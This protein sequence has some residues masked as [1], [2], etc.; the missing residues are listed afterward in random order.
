MSGSVAVS[1]RR[2]ASVGPVS[3]GLDLPRPSPHAHRS[4][5][6]DLYDKSPHTSVVLFKIC[7]VLMGAT[8]AL[9]RTESWI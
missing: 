2:V 8:A 4:R 3:L 7:P 1:L 5:R 6:V 9:L